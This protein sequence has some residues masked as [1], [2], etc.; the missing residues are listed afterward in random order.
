[1]KIITLCF[2]VSAML[3]AQQQAEV[4]SWLVDPS[5]TKNQV[6]VVNVGKNQYEALLKSLAGLAD[7]ITSS[8]AE[9]QPESMVSPK[10]TFTYSFG[11]VNISFMRKSFG[12]TI[13]K[14]DTLEVKTMV[15]FYGKLQYNKKGKKCFI[16]IGSEFIG[17]ANDETFNA[18]S[19]DSQTTE[20]QSLSYGFR[21]MTL[22]DLLAELEQEG[23]HIE[24]KTEYDVT[25]ALATYPLTKL[26]R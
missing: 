14:R 15:S 13:K 12:E 16:N 10:S 25:Y 21:N 17:I 23:V 11:N 4:K 19:Y 22:S 7:K 24:F 3:A 5:Y 20:E 8:Q 6:Y 2:L 9:I 1:M 18:S 26:L